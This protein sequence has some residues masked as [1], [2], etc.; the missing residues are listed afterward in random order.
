MSAIMITMSEHG[1][2]FL[3]AFLGT[4]SAIGLLLLI[5][6]AQKAFD[7]FCR[8]DYNREQARKGRTTTP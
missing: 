1:Y 3:A 7:E 2:C 5:A 8:S 6:K 4:W